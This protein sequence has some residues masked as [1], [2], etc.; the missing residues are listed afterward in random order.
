MVAPRAKVAYSHGARCALGRVTEV[1]LIVD[2]G[3][4]QGWRRLGR[5]AFVYTLAGRAQFRDRNGVARDL[6]PGDALL[7]FPDVEHAYG[8]APGARWS[9]FYLVFEGPVFEL[10][11][12]TGV[13]DPADPVRPARPVA[14]WLPRLEAIPEEPRKSSA[15][16]ALLEICRLQ[17]VLAEL[18]GRPAGLDAT[19]R[20][21]DAIAA[22]CALLEA[23]RARNLSLT[24]LARTVGM[25]Y[26]SFRKA[27]V[28][29]V[30]VPPARFRLARQIDRACALI[31]RGELSDKEIA[32]RLG[33]YDEF[34]FSHRFKSVTGLSPRTF[35][36]AQS[37]SR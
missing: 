5:F 26:E 37:V 22:A 20:Q 10:W 2:S 29:A 9:E 8:P 17:A 23:D 1:G 36:R 7:L 25:S 27:F 33:F 19:G 31:R 6:E 24:A 16:R 21:A 3:G 15:A 14:T 34:H 28:R 13:L 30:G 35:R 4:P 12:Q 11:R 32:A 18:W